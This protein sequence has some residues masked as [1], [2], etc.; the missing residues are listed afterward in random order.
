MFSKLFGKKKEISPAAAAP[1]I[2]GLHLGGAFELDALKL[3]LI[4]PQLIVENVA[5][6]HLI[7]A[8]GEV[9]LDENS[10]VLR[11]YTDDDSFLQVLLTGGRT[12]NHI[13]DVKLWY[14]YETKSVGSE[15][16]W[17]V[18]LASGISKPI[19]ECDG[20]S[21]SRVWESTG[22]VSPPVAMSEKTFSED[23]AISETDQFAMLYERDI[24]AGL[25]EYLMYVGEEKLS[26]N[27][28]DRCFVVST[29]FDIQPA[30]IEIIG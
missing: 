19:A 26:D 28:L 18:L 10:T 3:R 7:Q 13:A 27:Q 15:A 16:D 14:F 4:E 2:M 8:V 17:E 29:G 20:R 5:K 25:H 11:Y 12:E 22:T 24:G 30:D 1:E 21:F 9:K 6:T 23:G